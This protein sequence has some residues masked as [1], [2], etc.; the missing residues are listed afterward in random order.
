MEYFKPGGL[1][2]E[3]AAKMLHEGVA[4]GK[5]LT[6]KQRRYFAAVAYGEKGGEK[7]KYQVGGIQ[8]PDAPSELFFTNDHTVNRLVYLAD[9]L[10]R[11]VASG[12]QVQDTEW[13]KS[14]ANHVGRDVITGLNIFNSRPDVQSK[15][16]EQRLSSF[17]NIYSSNQELQ[18]IKDQIRS[19]GY[20]VLD[21]YRNSL[22]SKPEEGIARNFQYGG[23]TLNEQEQR[24][25]YN[26][27]TLQKYA[28]LDFPADSPDQVRYFTP[29]SVPVLAVDEQGNQVYL[30]P[31]S[32]GASLLGNVTEYIMNRGGLLQGQWEL[33]PENIR[34]K[35]QF[36]YFKKM[37]GEVC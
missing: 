35:V 25:G 20:G 29:A 3:K 5:K 10:N 30:G 9:L 23:K 18:G 8:T 15:T 37:G 32:Q 21:F 12:K 6:P 7:D 4:N 26:S 11:V 34:R 16:P 19:L 36:M 17:Y 22:M 27:P 31:G 14:L 13:G 1:T 2:K 24:L 33:V 28:Q